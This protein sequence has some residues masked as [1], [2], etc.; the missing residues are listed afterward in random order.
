[1]ALGNDTVINLVTK[2]KGNKQVDR[3]ARKINDL[4][5]SLQGLAGANEA[6]GQS[7]DRTSRKLTQQGV[8][9]G[10]AAGGLAGLQSQIL[11]AQAAQEALNRSSG[12]LSETLDELGDIAGGR[13]KGIEAIASSIHN[14]LDEIGDLDGVD[15]DVLGDFDEAELR[16]LLKVSAGIKD[17]VKDLRR[18]RDVPFD[19]DEWEGMVSSLQDVRNAGDEELFS[20]LFTSEGG[21]PDQLPIDPSEYEPGQ[22][23]MDPHQMFAL[24]QQDGIDNLGDVVDMDPEELADIT[25]TRFALDDEKRSISN[26]PNLASDSQRG[27][28]QAAVDDLIQADIG[29]LDEFFALS[30]DELID[31]LG[32][33]DDGSS[34]VAGYGQRFND[35]DSDL[36]DPSLLRDQLL[37]QLSHLDGFEQIDAAGDGE[38]VAGAQG[39]M[40]RARMYADAHAPRPNIPDDNEAL[41]TLDNIASQNQNV[42]NLLEASDS[43]SDLL[44]AIGDGPPED[45]QL[46]Q[47]ALSG[48]LNESFGPAIS[49]A[50]SNVEGVGGQ[51]ELKNIVG[52]TMGPSNRDGNRLLQQ[53][54]LS[55][56]TADMSSVLPGE[57]AG[58]DVPLSQEALEL[59]L[60]QELVESDSQSHSKAVEGLLEQLYA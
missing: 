59:E 43:P 30:D 38:G 55:N 16:E 11:A 14:N 51:E 25:D 1:M 34:F 48:S 37:D 60:M 36:D 50:A 56:I 9:A 57:S 12:N 42:R 4:K 7:A 45:E 54:I 3:A 33:I 2:V 13:A 32:Q 44:T 58:A 28:V 35:P 49:D 18:M 6:A 27:E 8:A 52:Q 47:K 19:T 10:T 53:E 5:R 29:T 22:T 15:A 24:S 46:I 41:Q 40:N 20:D 23:P 21:F 31:R 39:A 17:N 26:L